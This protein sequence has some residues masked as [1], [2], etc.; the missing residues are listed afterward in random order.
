MRPIATG[1]IR[2]LPI[3]LSSL[4]GRRGELRAVMRSR[5]L[6]TITGV[7]DIAF[8]ANTIMACSARPTSF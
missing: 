5:R 4:V 6:V 7:G 3:E 2:G 1:Q 8:A